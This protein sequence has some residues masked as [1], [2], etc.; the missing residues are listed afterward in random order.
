MVLK[1][2]YTIKNQ[3]KSIAKLN[4]RYLKKLHNYLTYYLFVNNYSTKESFLLKII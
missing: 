2:V 3:Y 1:I 4:Y